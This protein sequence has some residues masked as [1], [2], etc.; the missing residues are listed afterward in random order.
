MPPNHHFIKI[1]IPN[2]ANYEVL[3]TAH[4]PDGCRP[5]LRAVP[6]Q[7]DQTAQYIGL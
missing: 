2:G 5:A 7:G 4:F 3:N 1:T 6:Q